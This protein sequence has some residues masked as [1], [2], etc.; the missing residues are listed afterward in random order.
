M[1]Q[2]P[3]AGPFTFV[4]TLLYSEGPLLQHS[5]NAQEIWLNAI[6]QQ[7]PTLYNLRYIE[8]PLSCQRHPPIKSLLFVTLS[9]V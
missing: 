9:K 1:Y 5:R 2:P 3:S 4:Q 6:E 8:N 7:E